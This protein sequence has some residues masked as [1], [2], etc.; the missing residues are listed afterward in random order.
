MAGMKIATSS[1]NGVRVELDNK[2]FTDCT[3]VNCLLIYAG[4]APPSLVRCRF[5]NS[6]FEFTGAAANSLAF[7]S[8]IYH[9]FGEAGQV[10]VENTFDA[11]RARN[12]QQVNISD[13]LENEK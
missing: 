11:I 6:G 12:P 7:L 8:A 3:F 9:G 10:I 2:E 13:K 4:G 5:D 1:F